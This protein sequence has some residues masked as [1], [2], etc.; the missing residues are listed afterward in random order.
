M[1]KIDDVIEL[2]KSGKLVQAKSILEEI[3][4]NDPTN[5]DALY[6]LGMCF[7]ELDYKNLLFRAAR[8]SFSL[9]SESIPSIA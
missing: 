8:P 3:I 5:I 9:S 6:N 4:K 2:L 1:A 7:T